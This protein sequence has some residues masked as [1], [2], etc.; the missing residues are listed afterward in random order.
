M[1]WNEIIFYIRVHSLHILYTHSIL[2][3]IFSFPLSIVESSSERKAPLSWLKK[4]LSDAAL[5]WKRPVT[6]FKSGSEENSLRRSF[7]VTRRGLK[8]QRLGRGI[9]L[10]IPSEEFAV[11]KGG[12]RALISWFKRRLAGGNSVSMAG[13]LMQC[14]KY[15]LR[16]LL[17]F[18]GGAPS[19]LVKRFRHNAVAFEVGEDLILLKATAA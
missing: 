19:H 1:R 9:L 8:P 16:R 2:Q 7:S 12:I 6:S 13:W 5:F 4:D 15:L 11:Q 18:S 17:C 10:S 3:I 14:I